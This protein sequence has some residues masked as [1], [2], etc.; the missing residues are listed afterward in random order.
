M[1]EGECRCKT[2]YSVSR[3]RI[4]LGKDCWRCELVNYPIVSCH[5]V[6]SESVDRSRLPRYFAI[7]D[8]GPKLDLRHSRVLLLIPTQSPDT[9]T[10]LRPFWP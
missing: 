10:H 4:R 2:S 8:T 5:S 6:L 1:M 9:R 3:D 7:L